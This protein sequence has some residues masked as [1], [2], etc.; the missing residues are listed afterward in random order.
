M[1]L[2]NKSYFH[3]MNDA[4]AIT[5]EPAWSRE[6]NMRRDVIIVFQ[7]CSKLF[8]HGCLVEASKPSRLEYLTV[9]CLL[10][11]G[12]Q[13][14]LVRG[15]GQRTN[16]SGSLVEVQPLVSLWFH[17]RT[18]AGTLDALKACYD[19]VKNQLGSRSA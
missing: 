15:C 3:A 19:L 1:L 7:N 4:L 11:F 18:A 12:L 14:P 17:N 10:G 13:K 2:G 8:N 6:T 5:T 16:E 9:P